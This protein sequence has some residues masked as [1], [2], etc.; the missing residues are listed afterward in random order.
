MTGSVWNCVEGYH[1]RAGIKVDHI[2]KL[3]DMF[4][5]VTTTNQVYVVMTLNPDDRPTSS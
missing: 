3:L 1:L 5:V 2:R 4:I